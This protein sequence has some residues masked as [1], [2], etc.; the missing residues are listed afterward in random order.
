MKILIVGGPHNGIQ[1]EDLGPEITM[2]EKQ[3]LPPVELFSALNA[4][5][6]T[7]PKTYTFVRYTKRRLT[8]YSGM[9][10]VTVYALSSLSPVEILR[11]YEDR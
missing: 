2:P 3:D 5:H 10:E 4:N 1:I 6:P 7:E 9:K 11:A 8:G